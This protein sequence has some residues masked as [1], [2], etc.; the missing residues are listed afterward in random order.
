[1]TGPRRFRLSIRIVTPSDWMLLRSRNDYRTTWQGHRH[2]CLMVSH[3]V[4]EYFL[5]MSHPMQNQRIVPRHRELK[6]A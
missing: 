2:V 6:I 1:M 5:G 4:G 3:I